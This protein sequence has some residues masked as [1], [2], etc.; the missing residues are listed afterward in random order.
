[1]QIRAELH[2][3]HCGYIAARVEGEREGGASTLRVIRPSNGPGVRLRPGRQPR[4]GR[5][6]GPLYLDEVEALLPP[7]ETAPPLLSQLY[8]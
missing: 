5:C 1:M 3:Y 2:C 8:S 7:P 6:G 4:C